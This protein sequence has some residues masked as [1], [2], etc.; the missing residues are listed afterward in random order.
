LKK[1]VKN[2]ETVYEEAAEELDEEQRARRTFVLTYPGQY[3][4]LKM[5]LDYV[6]ANVRSR[7]HDAQVTVGTVHQTKGSQYP[8]VFLHDDFAYNGDLALDLGARRAFQQHIKVA[9]YGNTELEA[10]AQVIEQFNLLF[11]ALTRAQTALFL[12]SSLQNIVSYAVQDEP[13]H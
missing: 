1:I 8:A 4:Q 5:D 3:T 10:Q 9:R 12:N 6:K 13:D 2:P 11:V 7:Y